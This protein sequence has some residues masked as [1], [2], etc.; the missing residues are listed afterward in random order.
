MTEHL[1]G[2]D[3]NEL[4]VVLNTALVDSGTVMRD[5]TEQEHI[6]TRRAVEDTARK[7]IHRLS[8]PE[9]EQGK[10]PMVLLVRCQQCTSIRRAYDLTYSRLLSPATLKKYAAAIC[11]KCGYQGMEIYAGQDFRSE[12]EKREAHEH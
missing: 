8:H 3:I 6:N 2:K 4:L 11:V 10:L 12:E 1:T 5:L 9:P 7:W